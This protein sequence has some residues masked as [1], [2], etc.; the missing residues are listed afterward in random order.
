MINPNRVNLQTQ[1]NIILQ[2]QNLTPSTQVVVGNQ[3]ATIVQA[4]GYS[5][6][7]QLPSTLQ[8]GTYQVEVSNEA[9]TAMADD[10]L[11]VDDTPAGPSQPVLLL[12]IG[13][14]GALLILLMRMARSPSL[15]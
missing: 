1:P 12:G 13:G 14:L 8:N 4:D 9:G 7:V 10:P 2:G 6:V 11:I 5:M 15:R 3:P